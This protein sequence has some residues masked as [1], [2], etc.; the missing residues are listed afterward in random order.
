[1]SATL[2]DLDTL[3]EAILAD[4]LD[5]LASQASAN[6]MPAI[7]PSSS[8]AVL[9]TTSATPDVAP[10]AASITRQAQITGASADAS[11]TPQLSTAKDPS[12]TS[13]SVEAAST[14][15]GAALAPSSPI[16]KLATTTTSLASPTSIE[17]AATLMTA[18][19]PTTALVQS[20]Q[21]QPRTSS[22]E[23]TSV[24]TPGTPSSS[25]IG[26]LSNL[27]A[28]TAEP[29]TTLTTT[30]ISSISSV[31]SASNSASAVLVPLASTT[32][33]TASITSSPTASSATDYNTSS[34][35]GRITA[36]VIGS[37]AVFATLCALV[38]WIYR[39]WNR[40]RH[41]PS[42][43]TRKS[44]P[45][46]SDRRSTTTSSDAESAVGYDRAAEHDVGEPKRTDSWYQSQ[47]QPVSPIKNHFRASVASS[48][49]DASCAAAAP[50]TVYHTPTPAA[51]YAPILSTPVPP[52]LNPPPIIANPHYRLKRADKYD[53]EPPIRSVGARIPRVE[54]PAASIADGHETL[55][56]LHVA[57]M[58][59]GDVTSAS[60]ASPWVTPRLGSDFGTP[61]EREIQPRYSTVKDGGLP[62]P[63]LMRR[64]GASSDG[65]S[66]RSSRA[67]S[68]ANSGRWSVA[69]TRM[70]TP[71]ELESQAPVKDD[72][73]WTASSWTAAIRTSVYNAVDSISG[74]RLLSGANTG[75]EDD[76]DAF[77]P[78]PKRSNRR[79]SVRSVDWQ[80]DRSTSTHIPS[81]VPEEEGD[82]DGDGARTAFSRSSSVYSNVVYGA[83]S[84]P[85]RLPEIEQWHRP[86]SFRTN[87]DMTTS[88]APSRSQSHESQLTDAEKRAR[89]LLKE[90]MGRRSSLGE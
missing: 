21:A 4:E 22:S 7:T 85:P 30:I 61:R 50:I 34:D 15:I 66:V 23:A 42:L 51:T 29:T 25:P 48:T 36:I 2:S 73:T 78:V 68:P 5:Q 12:P 56:A 1:M 13:T 65:D 31:N 81:P 11:S 3:L 46:E 26:S 74:G 54:T 83:G 76:E 88:T 38:S 24:L 16:A 69:P 14:E 71:R 47:S 72:Q 64:P 8:F 41:R 58:M 35:A 62:V 55:G 44:W 45:F 20:A 57:N 90:R 27:A 19:P 79:P 67:S 60:G 59:P 53:T 32:D 87:T 18:S 40:H 33:A 43:N 80:S 17:K 86:I 28:P 70:R 9:S 10:A 77:T 84:Q 52:A 75:S 37:L 6:S 49:D 82:M 63:W 39:T 89:D